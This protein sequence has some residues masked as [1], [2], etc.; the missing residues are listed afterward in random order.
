MTEVAVELEIEVAAD[1]AA[2]VSFLAS[3]PATALS[4][5]RS[6][7]AAPRFCCLLPPSYHR[8][9]ARTPVAAPEFGDMAVLIFV[10]ARLTWRP[11]RRYWLAV[12]ACTRRIS[13]C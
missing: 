7:L 3:N 8:S 13:P 11:A 2:A 12:G 6:S 4:A 9:Q 1:L 10:F 5:L